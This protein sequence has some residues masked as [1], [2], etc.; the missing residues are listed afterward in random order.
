MVDVDVD[1]CLLGW[2][3]GWLVDGEMPEFT[4][5]HIDLSG[6]TCGSYNFNLF[7]NL[8]RVPYVWTIGAQDEAEHFLNLIDS[9]GN[10]LIELQAWDVCRGCQIVE[11]SKFAKS[12]SDFSDPPGSDQRRPCN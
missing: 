7:P 5:I 1:A 12:A 9:S 6:G 3:V 8:L 4:H 2:L 10:G 11:S